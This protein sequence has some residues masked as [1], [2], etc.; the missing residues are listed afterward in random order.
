MAE[1]RLF[2]P[3]R[4]CCVCGASVVAWRRSLGAEDAKILTLTPLLYGRGSGK[5]AQRC[6]ASVLICDGCL[7]REIAPHRWRIGG[8]KLWDAVSASLA[9]CYSDLLS[10]GL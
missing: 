3:S 8:S 4:V 10:G 2:K 5:G 9:K 7:I 1:P 6:A